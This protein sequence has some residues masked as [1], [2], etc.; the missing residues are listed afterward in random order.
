[1]NATSLNPVSLNI[2]TALNC[3][4]KAL[5][6]LYRLSKV[7]SKPF[8]YYTGKK[9]V[10]SAGREVVIYLLVSGLGGL[11][12]STACGWL[13]AQT[14]QCDSAWLNIGTAGHRDM[15]SG[16]I[17]RVHRAVSINDGK[18]HYPALV[19]KWSGHSSLLISYDSACTE[20]P[21]DALVDMEGA[22]FFASVGL[23]VTNELAQ[24][25]KV[26]SDNQTESVARLNAA[27][28]SQLIERNV[29]AIDA[30][31]NGLV[32][33]IPP[34]KQ[35]AAYTRL[36]S[37]L[38]C[39]VSHRQQYVELVRKLESLHC[40]DKPLQQLIEQATTMQEVLQH[41]NKKLDATQP[42]LKDMVG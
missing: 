2:V 22:A 35:P 36:V 29:A 27:L 41:L 11:N 8:D 13:A 30:F 19:A 42:T 5:I 40:F 26:V 3:E 12:M 39:T 24:S 34:S 9:K 16:E 33:L 23:F 37:H 1:M 25:L 18:S 10:D 17:V 32:E 21:Q 4:A 15:K 6:D 14:D 20:Y 38:H 7:R 28:I 31:A